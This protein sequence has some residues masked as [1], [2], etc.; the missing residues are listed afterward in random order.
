MDNKSEYVYQKYSHNRIRTNDNLHF[1][2]RA[3]NHFWGIGNPTINQ[4]NKLLY[5]HEAIKAAINLKSN[6]D[7]YQHLYKDIKN[8]LNNIQRKRKEI[9]EQEKK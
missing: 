1:T 8:A 6:R 7:E 2:I 3:M 9:S 5:A 4:E